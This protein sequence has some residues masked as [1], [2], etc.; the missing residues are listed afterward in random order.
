M[1]T[2]YIFA[3]SLL[4]SL[5]FTGCQDLDTIPEGDTVTADQKEEIYEKN[6]AQFEAA[7]NAIYFQFKAFMPNENALGTERHNDIGYATIMLATDANTMDVV[8]T[9][10]GYNWQ[11][12][13]LT[14]DDHLDYTSY[15]CQMVWNDLYNIIYSSNNAIASLDLETESAEE[16]MFLGQALAARAFAYFNLAQLYQFNY[17]GNQDKPCVPIIT[18]QNSAEAEANGVARATVQAVYDQIEA[19]LESAISYFE[20]CEAAGLDRD[21]RRYINQSVAYGIRARVHLT[22][23]EWAAAAE[24]AQT[25]ISLASESNIYPASI[26]EVNHP[27]FS[28]MNETNWMWG[29]YVSETDDLVSSGI[30]NWP[31]H[32]G[33]LS[34]G[35]A[36]YSGGKQINKAL[37]NTIPDTDV[38]KGWWLNEERTSPNLNAEQQYCMTSYAGFPAY[39][40]VKFGPYNDE[41]YT[42][43]NANDIPLMRIEEMYLILAEAQAMGG[44]TGTGRATLENFI[45]T[46]RDPEYTCTA[47]SATDIQEEIYRQRRIELW[48][49]GLIWY[50]IMRLNKGVDR[51]GAGFQAS[52]VYNIEAGSPLLLWLIPQ[53]EINANPALTTSDNNPTA[54]T[55]QPVQDITE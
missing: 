22:K 21:D 38:R 27:T 17:V 9:D 19:D 16:Q 10:N 40:Q 55:P 28:D 13:S 47:A 2:K 5:A 44:N 15:E 53:N 25:A 45:Q 39:T 4:L 46:Y 11:G 20:Q 42:S 29:I 41:V 36:W 7:I 3:S 32:M 48:G 52:C 23:Q 1:K 51:R 8:S 30:V 37:Y 43:T 35:Y 33:S 12:N 31:S 14:Y 18:D 49:E 50:D 26:E 34:Y 6:P 24:D 54:S